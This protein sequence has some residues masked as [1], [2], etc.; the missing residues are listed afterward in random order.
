[1]TKVDH[2]SDNTVIIALLQ[3]RNIYFRLIRVLSKSIWLR[4]WFKLYLYKIIGTCYVYT[5]YHVHRHMYIMQLVLVTRKMKLFCSVSQFGCAWLMF[6]F[7]WSQDTILTFSMK[8]DWF[9][10]WINIT[11]KK[12]T[13]EQFCRFRNATNYSSLTH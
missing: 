9:H 2:Q 6:F 12:I 13:Y 4:I 10:I 7:E 8:F 1:M 5:P 3:S 11:F